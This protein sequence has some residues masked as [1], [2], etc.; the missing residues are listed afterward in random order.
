MIKIS[1]IH[2]LL[3]RHGRDASTPVRVPHSRLPDLP[4]QTL[5]CEASICYRWL[6]DFLLQGWKLP[7]F[8]RAL[9]G[10]LA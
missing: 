5:S 10:S 6:S 7:R 4:E 3:N 8:L 9:V 1:T 2:M